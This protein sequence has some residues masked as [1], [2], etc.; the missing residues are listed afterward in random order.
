M[1][2]FYK[3][4]VSWGGLFLSITR[5]RIAF[6]ISTVIKQLQ[7]IYVACYKYMTK[8]NL[9]NQKNGNEVS[10]YGWDVYAKGWAPLLS[11]GVVRGRG[12]WCLKSFVKWLHL[13]MH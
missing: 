9:W 8:T 2:K 12:D 6:E 10:I 3:Y 11:T 5:F 7:N 4:T 1:P 13:C